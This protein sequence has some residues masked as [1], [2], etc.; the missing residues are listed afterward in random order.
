MKKTDTAVALKKAI[1]A[2]KREGKTI[3]FVPTMGALHQGHV[4]LVERSARENGCTVVSIFV[5]PTQFNDPNDLQ[6]YPRALDAD[7][8]LLE[9]CGCDIVFTPSVE[10]MYPTP[11]ARVFDFGLLDKVMEG[12][13]RPGHF[14]GVAQIVSKLFD[15][16]QPDRAYFGEK[17]FQQLAII[18][19]MAKQLQ[20]PAEIVGCPIIREPDGLAMSSRNT[21]LTPAQREIAPVIAK[22]L[23]N[24]RNFVPSK[25]VN[26]VT[27]SVIMAVNACPELRTEYFQIVDGYTLQP[28]ADWDETGYIVGCIAVFCGEIRLIDNIKYKSEHHVDRSS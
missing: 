15:A 12:A 4:S 26:E 27:E 10:E 2:C 1:E 21:R 11:D 17:D 23:K 5:N 18:C 19:E 20:W 7:L 13:F 14:N 6:N 28:V 16:V 22:T 24:S 25:T 9:K 8:D 3:G